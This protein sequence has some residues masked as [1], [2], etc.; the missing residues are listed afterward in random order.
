L[1]QQLLQLLQQLPFLGL[2]CRRAILGDRHWPDQ[3]PADHPVAVQAAIVQLDLLAKKG[4]LGL[5][6]R[7]AEHLAVEISQPAK[8]R[9]VETGVVVLA[10]PLRRRN[11]AVHSVFTL[12]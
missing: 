12:R 1:R 5:E 4:L 3:Q 7:S 8:F 6:I 9:D 11:C 2:L 10:W